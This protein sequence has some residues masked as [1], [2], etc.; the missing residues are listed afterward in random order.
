[1]KKRHVNLVLIG[2]PGCGKGTQA[3]RICEK[4]GLTYVSTGNLI[5]EEIQAN[6]AIGIKAKELS[7]QGHFLDDATVLSLVQKKLQSSHNGV[8]FDGFPRTLTQAHAIE[9]LI[10]IHAVLDIQVSEEEVIKRISSRFMVELNHEQHTFTS[11][12]EAETY[13][14]KNG[15]HVFQR[16]DDKPN[17]VKERLKVYHTMTE[18]LIS[19]YGKKHLLYIVNGEKSIE[20][21]WADIQKVINKKLQ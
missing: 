11:K 13:V 3:E 21:V 1:M 12:S 15:G 14:K 6:S 10:P 5:R 8:L 17:V 4:F 9:S 19:F 7:A 2:P 20:N 16:E 18:P